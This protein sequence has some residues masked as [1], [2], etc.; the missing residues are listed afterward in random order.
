[1][2][3]IIHFL[4]DKNYQF[5]LLIALVTAFIHFLAEP[6]RW[7]IYLPGNNFIFKRFLAIFSFTALSGYLLPFKLGIPFRIYLL[8][9]KANIEISSILALLTIDGFIYYGC[10]SLATLLS[11]FLG[12]KFNFSKPQLPHN[13][14]IEAA[15]LVLAILLTGLFIK[16]I[17]RK[18]SNGL[19]T[20]QKSINTIKTVPLKQYSFNCVLIAIDIGG[21]ILKHYALFVL[22]SH[23]LSLGQTS[24]IVCVSF[25]TGLFSMMP[26]G[27][28][29][30]DATMIFLS[31]Q[32]GIPIEHALLIPIINRSTNLFF[33]TGLGIW[34]GFQLGFTPLK[35]IKHIRNRI[36]SHKT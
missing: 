16:K 36:S 23:P 15:I 1:M 3:T 27:L 4:P 8:R 35:G 7:K 18:T 25:T 13:N 32:A 6:I 10:W 20:I 14:Y 22:L 21:H 33:S 34:G 11:I 29:G 30:Y 28:L 9:G 5:W 31:Q 19:K 2:S 17:L 12:P 26:M 24:V